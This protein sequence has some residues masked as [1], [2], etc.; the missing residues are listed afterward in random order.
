MVIDGPPIPP[1][2]CWQRLSD[3]WPDPD[4]HP[5]LRVGWW[6]GEEWWTE[7]AYNYPGPPNGSAWVAPFSGLFIDQGYPGETFWHPLPAA[8]EP[9][10]TTP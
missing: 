3:V 9:P 7:L 4:E 6:D 8:P 5:D 1:P 10:E 2:P